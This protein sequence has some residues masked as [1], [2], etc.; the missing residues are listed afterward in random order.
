ML[1]ALR[2][3]SLALGRSSPSPF[4]KLSTSSGFPGNSLESFEKL[5]NEW[6]T[7]YGYHGSPTENIYSIITFGLQKK[8]S[9]TAAFGEGIYLAKDN[10]V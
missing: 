1:N 3:N 8:Y 2:K 6:G 7:T 9:K 10:Q 5:K 4:R